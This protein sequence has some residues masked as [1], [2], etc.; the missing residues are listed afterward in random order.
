MLLGALCAV[1]IGLMFYDVGINRINALHF[2]T[3]IF[4]TVGVDEL[5]RLCRK[6]RVVPAL[7]AAAYACCF[8]AFAGV[9]FTSYNDEIALYFRQGVGQAVAFVKQQGFD[10][11]AVDDSVYYS[12]ILFY[13]QT[14]HEVYAASVD[15]AGGSASFLDVDGFGRY[16]F[17]I[18]YGALEEDTA[19]L[20]PAGRAGELTA[21]GY[22]T[23]V[24]DGYAVA[25]Q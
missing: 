6:A 14:P 13:D 10:Q 15:Y 21:A 20:I 19:Y 12:Q 23:A 3:L 2:Y 24:F 7:V 4:I 25:W 16:T 8:L 22:Q 17:G 5:V 9:Y 18:D 11:V 1:L